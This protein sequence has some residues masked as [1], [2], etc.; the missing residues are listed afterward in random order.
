MC[1]DFFEDLDFIAK[2]GQDNPPPKFVQVQY[3]EITYP[4]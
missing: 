1:S 3:K 4:E 2:I